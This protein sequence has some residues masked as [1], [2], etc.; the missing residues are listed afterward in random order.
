MAEPAVVMAQLDDYK[1]ELDD[2]SRKLA[3]LQIELEPIED[4]YQ[5]FVDDFEASM[6]DRHVDGEGK[7]PAEAMREKL[8]R[9]GMSPELRGQHD[10]LNKRRKRIE[11]RVETLGKLVGAQRSILSALKEEMA[12]TR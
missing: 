5:A 11:K 3:R 4:K 9:R 10:A 7:W 12:A 1:N 8:A 2:L 6:W